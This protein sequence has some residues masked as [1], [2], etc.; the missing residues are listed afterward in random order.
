MERIGILGAGAFGTAMAAVAKRAG[1]DVTLWAYEADVAD[2]IQQ[3]L[4]A[5]GAAV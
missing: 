5:R 1:R 3:R 2:A 4:E